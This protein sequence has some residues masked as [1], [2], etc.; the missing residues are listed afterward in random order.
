MTKCILVN[1]M[2]KGAIDKLY[3]NQW[4]WHRRNRLNCILVEL[5]RGGM[6][7]IVFQSMGWAEEQNYI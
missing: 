6:G 1:G 2:G 5:S 7:K 4:I 3:F